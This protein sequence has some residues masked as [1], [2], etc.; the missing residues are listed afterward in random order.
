MADKKLK[1]GVEIKAG[2][3][4]VANIGKMTD[5]IKQAGISTKEL[6]Q[7][8]KN[9]GSTK[10]LEAEFA[11]TA[12]Q[13]KTLKDRQSQLTEAMHKTRQSMTDA[14][15]AVKNVALA[16]KQLQKE[17]T[18]AKG[19]LTDLTR[20]TQK[21]HDLAQ[22]K[23]TLGIDAD[24]KARKEIERVKSAYEKLK[25]SGTLSSA[26]LAR[27]NELHLKKVTQLEAGMKDIPASARKASKDVGLL[28]SATGKLGSTCNTVNVS[29]PP[30]WW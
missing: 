7:Q 27:A 16:E 29:K 24:D 14:G 23:I 20:E 30:V 8:G 12:K 6:S 10:K 18:K 3:A 1:V 9:L 21:L 13:A 11:R 4:G 2:V 15:I 17:T 5:T 19:E 26:E 28:Q 25:Q 22:A